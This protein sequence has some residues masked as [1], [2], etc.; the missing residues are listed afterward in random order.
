MLWTQAGGWAADGGVVAVTV[1][2]LDPVR[3]PAATVGLR[4]EQ[5]TVEKLI[6]EDPVEPL[7]TDRSEVGRAGSGSVDRSLGQ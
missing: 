1:V 4:P 3:K 5:T 2:Q 6:S 7:F